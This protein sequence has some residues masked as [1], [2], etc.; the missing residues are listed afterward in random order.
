MGRKESV[1]CLEK[2]NTSVSLKQVIYDSLLE[3]LNLFTLMTKCKMVTLA[4][5][6]K[7]GGLA[8]LH[9]KIQKPC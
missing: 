4:F 8:T 9:L 1:R 2:P 5:W 3:C 7:K 6:K